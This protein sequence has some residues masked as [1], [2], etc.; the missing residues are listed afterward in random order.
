MK[1]VRMSA[2]GRRMRVGMYVR[3]VRRNGAKYRCDCSNGAVDDSRKGIRGDR[4]SVYRAGMP[5][6]RSTP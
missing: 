3:S 6:A 2:E 5:S 1:S 4:T